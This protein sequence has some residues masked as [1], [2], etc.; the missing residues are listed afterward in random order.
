MFFYF[1]FTIYVS[2]AWENTSK[3]KYTCTYFS[4]F[5][6]EKLVSLKS[7]RENFRRK[8]KPEDNLVELRR[9]YQS[10]AHSLRFVVLPTVSQIQ[11]KFIN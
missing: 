7:G 5:F 6:V 9:P 10:A 4:S 3:R 1:V 11:F 2:L 8:C